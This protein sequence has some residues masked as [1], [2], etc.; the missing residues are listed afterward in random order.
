M[1]GIFA[2]HVGLL[3]IDNYFR[4]KE[5]EFT[6]VSPEKSDHMATSYSILFFRVVNMLLFVPALFMFIIQLVLYWV[7]NI[8]FDIYIIIQVVLLSLVWIFRLVIS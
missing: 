1:A 3:L 6:S 2:L 8:Y 5:L 4:D 7:K